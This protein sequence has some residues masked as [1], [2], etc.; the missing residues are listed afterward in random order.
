MYLCGNVYMDRK[1]WMKNV[2]Y[3]LRFISYCRWFWC[4]WSCRETC[5]TEAAVYTNCVFFSTRYWNITVRWWAG[6]RPIRNVI[7]LVLHWH[8]RYKI[9]TQKFWESSVRFTRK[10]IF[11]MFH[12]FATASTTHI[13]GN[14]MTCLHITR[15]DKTWQ[16]L[17]H[18]ITILFKWW[19]NPVPSEHRLHPF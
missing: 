10:C 5:W 14:L 17:Q 6:K 3:T 16:D 2:M 1:S 18:I 8:Y 12:L 13:K 9:I 7:L 15:Y 19:A 11:T 4:N